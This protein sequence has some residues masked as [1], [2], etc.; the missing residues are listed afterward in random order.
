MSSRREFLLNNIP[1]MPTDYD[2]YSIDNEE[3]KILMISKLLSS[4]NYFVNISIKLADDE[5]KEKKVILLVQT[6][7]N[8]K[9]YIQYLKNCLDNIR[10]ILCCK[11]E[12]TVEEA[13]YKLIKEVENYKYK[14]LRVVHFN[15]ENLWDRFLQIYY[16]KEI[17]TA[18]DSSSWKKIRLSITN[19]LIEEDFCEKQMKKDCNE[20]LACDINKL[21][22]NASYW[23]GEKIS[24][25][26]IE[27]TNKIIQCSSIICKKCNQEKSYS[28]Y[29]SLTKNLNCSFW[30]WFNS[31]KFHNN[32]D[33]WKVSLT[34]IIKKYKNLIIDHSLLL[35]EIGVLDSIFLQDEL[36][37]V[38]FILN[39]KHLKQKKSSL[40]RRISTTLSLRRENF[41]I[42]PDSYKVGKIVNVF[43]NFIGIQLNCKIYIGDGFESVI[44]E[45]YNE[46]LEDLSLFIKESFTQKENAK[47]ISLHFN[48][49]KNKIDSF[50][51]SRIAIPDNVDWRKFCPQFEFSDYQF[52]PLAEVGSLQRNFEQDFIKIN[53]YKLVTIK[54]VFN[55]LEFFLFHLAKIFANEQVYKI[56]NEKKESNFIFTK[57]S[58]NDYSAINRI[59]Y[60]ISER[61]WTL[62]PVNSA[63]S[64]NKEDKNIPIKKS[65][66]E[67][68]KNVSNYKFSIKNVSKIVSFIQKQHDET[69]LIENNLDNNTLKDNNFVNSLIGIEGENQV[70]KY[71]HFLLT[72]LR[73]LDNIPSYQSLWD[74]FIE[75]K[76][77]YS[78]KFIESIK[79]QPWKKLVFDH[80]DYKEIVEKIITEFSD[81]YL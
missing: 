44:I 48:S 46:N 54:R 76:K 22:P 63:I 20:C 56:I 79:I 60:L 7:N 72:K 61:K 45:N 6:N 78:D 28:S 65:I 66:D 34:V 8:E 67:I 42:F 3:E 36:K 69:F 70:I 74:L 19:Y 39:L 24:K 5:H 47:K 33:R 23:I 75:S 62:L 80:E 17:I 58:P 13:R 38:D 25:R 35:E 2:R 53:A 14:T 43:L 52:E 77:N 40:K 55:K 26:K 10:K 11:E 73:E 16:L 1:R 9:N 12:E 81:Q 41:Y 68:N 49:F 4:N 37:L 21:L 64:L 18:D 31:S 29:Q 32:K 30:Q 50:K 15:K 51:N 59:L 57:I 27:C 71:Y